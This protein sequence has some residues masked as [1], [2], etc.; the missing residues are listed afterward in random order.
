MRP[1][2][3]SLEARQLLSGN[4]LALSTSGH[5]IITGDA[6]GNQIVMDG[7]GLS[8]NQVRISGTNG[9]TINRKSS[10]V[11]RTA[12]R[13]DIQLGRGG[14]TLTIRNVR[15][16][17]YVRIG[18]MAS[19]LIDDVQ[20]TQTLHVI[21][22][23]QTTIQDSTIGKNLVITAAS[24]GG[25]VTLLANDVKVNTSI[26][27]GSQGDVVRIDDCVFEGKTRI[28]TL[29]G[30]DRIEIER[31]GYDVGSLTRFLGTA[32]I[33]LSAGDDE[34]KMGIF[35]EPG[36]TAEFALGTTLNGGDGADTITRSAATIYT[37]PAELSIVNFETDIVVP[38]EV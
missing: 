31:N 8:A 2:C 16:P 28:D 13:T 27:G 3:E 5:M 20:V 32:Q 25:N 38:A 22:Q 11:L 1:M 15:L 12:A 19:L 34:V 10:V 17:G 14:D 37:T 29:A 26:R 35:G 4:V 30:N 36:N 6:R 18:G 7:A 33:Y 24:R 21:S 23:T 9:T